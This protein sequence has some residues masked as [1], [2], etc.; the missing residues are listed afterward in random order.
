MQFPHL[1]LPLAAV[2]SAID[3]RFSTAMHCGGGARL[4]CH[5]IN[6]QQCCRIQVDA[7]SVSFI[8]IATNWHLLTRAYREKQGTFCNSEDIMNSF[9]SNGAT[10][11]CHGTGG[12]FPGN[13]RGANYGFIDKRRATDTSDKKACVKPDLL[14]L[15]DGQEYEI[16]DLD[17][18]VTAHMVCCP[19]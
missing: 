4:V 14:V 13:Y 7:N 18:D 8:A 17:D 5:N 11:V 1:I 15:A 16:A 6:P 19:T 3:V 12:I 9:T 2:A 10:T